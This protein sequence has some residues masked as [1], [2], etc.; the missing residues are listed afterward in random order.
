MTDSLQYIIIM[1]NIS[2]M[3]DNNS[4]FTHIE[5]QHWKYIQTLFYG[6]QPSMDISVLQTVCFVPGKRKPFLFL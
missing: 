2:E 6:H 1:S 4:T 3:C 5:I